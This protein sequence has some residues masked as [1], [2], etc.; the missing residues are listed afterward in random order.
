MPLGLFYVFAT[1]CSLSKTAYFVFKIFSPSSGLSDFE[2]DLIVISSSFDT[3]MNASQLLVYTLL[4]I[5][6]RLYPVERDY[7]SRA[8]AMKL[9]VERQELIAKIILS[10]LILAV[11]IMIILEITVGFGPEIKNTLQ[12]EW[13]FFCY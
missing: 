3:S 13:I 7:P 5:R 12:D 1:A 4:I 6:L 8:K 11:P 10:F 2:L 9:Q